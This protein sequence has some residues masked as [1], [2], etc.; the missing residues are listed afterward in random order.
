MSETPREHT[1]GAQMLRSIH[2]LTLLVVILSGL[3]LAVTLGGLW[4]AS[5]DRGNLRREVARNSAVNCAV[6]PDV[7]TREAATEAQL[8]AHPQGAPGFP[9]AVLNRSLATQ[10]ALAAA[11]AAYTCPA[12]H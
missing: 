12:G 4:Y 6:K 8:A 9:L 10:Q 2:R 11:L 1:L 5:I 7:E 3:L